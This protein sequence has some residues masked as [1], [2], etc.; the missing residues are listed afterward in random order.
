MQIR[1][2]LSILKLRRGIILA[3]LGVSTVYG[4]LPITRALLIARP[5]RKMIPLSALTSP[6]EPI[7]FFTDSGLRVQ[8]WY[9]PPRNDA[10]VIIAHG[11]GGNRADYLE[12][13]A[14]V[15]AQGYG[16]LLLDLLA[17]GES[18][19]QR[20]SLTGE[21]ILAA[22]RYVHN[23][24]ETA[25]AKIGLWGFS[26]GGLVSLQAAAQT[27]DIHAVIADGPFPVVSRQDMP[28]AQTFTDW[29]WIPFDAVQWQ[30]LRLLGIRPAMS[31]TTALQQITCDILLIA[32]TQNSGEQRVMRKYAAVPNAQIEL[33]EV[34]AAGHVESW[35][36]CGETYRER[37]L[38]FLEKALLE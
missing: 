22:I 21:E 30:V 8:G 14:F 11:Y 2:H 1:K 26:L 25:N 32:G 12:Q 9:A 36:V 10:V 4:V 35:R 29:L 27:Q 31:T 23:Q 33:W 17:H 28:V 20:L 38:E 15:V 19:G 18:G 34:T 3:I 16:V 7:T 37:V 6:Y 13:A 24:Q 5:P